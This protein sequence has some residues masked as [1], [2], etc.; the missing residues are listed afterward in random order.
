MEQVAKNIFLKVAQQNAT[1]CLTGQ[2]WQAVS[3]WE[4]GSPTNPLFWVTGAG[5]GEQEKATQ[6]PDA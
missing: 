3:P 5:S 4:I 6:E 2:N 1:L